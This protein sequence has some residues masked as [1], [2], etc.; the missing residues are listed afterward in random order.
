MENGGNSKTLMIV[1]V[2]PNAVNLSETLSS[3]NFSARARNAVL[4]LGNR[5]TIKK[6]R[7][8]ANDARKELYE[9]EK[10][11]QDLKQET[12]GLRQSLKEAN[13]QCILL[14]N[15]VQKAW[16]VSLTLQSDLK[17]L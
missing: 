13:D 1:N 2:C 9:R 17:V 11:I 4:S 8:I 14:Y 6:W 15:E 5:D 12:V 10:E 3:L 16:K 7:D